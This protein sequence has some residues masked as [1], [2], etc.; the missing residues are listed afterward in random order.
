[1]F[2]GDRTRG[3]GAEE[4]RD[5]PTELAVGIDV[6]LETTREQPLGAQHLGLAAIAGD[7]AAHVRDDIGRLR[8]EGVDQ[9]SEVRHAVLGVGLHGHEQG[10]LGLLGRGGFGRDAHGE[11][12]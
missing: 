4:T 12:S 3:I 2:G 11:K 1:M 10:L 6:D 9:A 7:E 8:A 5:L